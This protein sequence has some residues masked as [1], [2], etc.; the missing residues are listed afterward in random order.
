MVLRLLS[1]DKVLAAANSPE[2]CERLGI[3]VIPETAAAVTGFAKSTHSAPGV[4]LMVDVGAMTLDVCAFRL[5]QEFGEPLAALYRP[6]APP[7]C[8]SVPL[9]HQQRKNRS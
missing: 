2:S 9:V 5:M 1:D 4:Y 3:A 6:G 8:R 7:R